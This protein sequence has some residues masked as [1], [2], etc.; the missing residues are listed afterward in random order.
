MDFKS[1]A[2]AMFPYWILGIMVIGSVILAGQKHLLRID[3]KAI[4]K[5]MKVL[6]LITIFRTIV[7]ELCKHNGA[8]EIPKFAEILPWT[9]SLTVFWEDAC[10]GLPLLLLKKMLDKKK[11]AKFIF[12][13]ILILTMISFG[14]AHVYQGFIAAFVLSFY[15][16]YSVRMGEK[17]GFGTVMICHILYDAATLLFAKY[18]LG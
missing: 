2:L 16:P 1:F 7:I 4:F 9:I 10:H 3:K 17:Y 12:I 13:P 18:F 8:A 15:I 5:W 11:W 6:I 14:F